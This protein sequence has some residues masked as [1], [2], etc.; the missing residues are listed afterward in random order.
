MRLQKEKR[1]AAAGPCPSPIRL[2][3]TFRLPSSE[4][5]C[6]QALCLRG[7]VA[8]LPVVTSLEGVTLPICEQLFWLLGPCEDHS[9]V[10]AGGLP[11]ASPYLEAVVTLSTP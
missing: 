8:E 4:L 6:P 5:A 9:G 1:G 11:V 10:S 3:S 7:L 2:L